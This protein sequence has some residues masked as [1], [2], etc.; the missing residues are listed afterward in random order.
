MR[1]R[2]GDLG[3]SWFLSGALTRRS[4]LQGQAV[5]T[6]YPYYAAM[7]NMGAWLALYVSGVGDGERGGAGGLSALRQMMYSEPEFVIHLLW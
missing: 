3:S 2:S 5:C 1:C 4:G 6:Q 7:G